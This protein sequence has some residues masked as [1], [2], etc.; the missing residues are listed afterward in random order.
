[1]V[2]EAGVALAAD[3]NGQRHGEQQQH[4][5]RCGRHYRRWWRLGRLWATAQ[6]TRAT[7]MLR[8]LCLCPLLSPCIFVD[9]FIEATRG[10][11]YPKK[12]SNIPPG[13]FSTFSRGL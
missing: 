5:L 12:R 3:C 7:H 13:P 2:G 11:T 9:M 8:S 1:M 6:R 10:V 4:L